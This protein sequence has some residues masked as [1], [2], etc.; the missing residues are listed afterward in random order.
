MLRAYPESDRT[1]PA[2]YARAAAEHRLSHRDSALALM[3]RLVAMQPANPWFRELRGQI[4]FE[5]GRP[6]EAVTAYREAVRLAP[7]QPSMHQGLGRR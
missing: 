7:D 6:R 5:T 4:M 3:D 1:T 2:L